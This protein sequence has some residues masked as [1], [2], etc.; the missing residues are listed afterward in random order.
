M[1]ATPFTQTGIRWSGAN[2][3]PADKAAMDVGPGPDTSGRPVEAMRSRAIPTKTPSPAQS[4]AATKLALSLDYMMTHLHQPISIST[5]CA[6]TGY[7][8]SRLFDLFKKATGDTPLNWFIR[9]RMRWAAGLLEGSGL[10]IKQIAWQVGY[11]DQFYFSRLF[12]SVHGIS[13]SEYRA[14]KASARVNGSSEL[15]APATPRQAPAGD[16]QRHSSS[17]G[18]RRVV[19]GGDSVP[20]AR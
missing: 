9:A 12:K 18:W 10:P 5:L 4:A 3:A 15:S 13:P 20:V 17:A 6:M 2:D 14:Q 7:S 1:Y 16:R 8:K 11:G 19:R